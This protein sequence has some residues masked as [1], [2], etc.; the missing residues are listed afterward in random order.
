MQSLALQVTLASSALCSGQPLHAITNNCIYSAPGGPVGGRSRI[1]MF[2]LWGDWTGPTTPTTDRCVVRIY[3]F[4]NVNALKIK[5][6]CNKSVATTP[7]GDLFLPLIREWQ[8]K[9]CD[10][11][12]S[13]IFA[14]STL[15]GKHRESQMKDSSWAHWNILLSNTS[16]THASGELK[17]DGFSCS[18]PA[19]KNKQAAWVPR[20]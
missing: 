5:Y 9:K 10:A 7:G 14:L 16:F 15:A 12:S 3:C 18:F 11:M 20:F 8:N 17:A 1:G 2:W 4:N 13:L 6:R 19:C